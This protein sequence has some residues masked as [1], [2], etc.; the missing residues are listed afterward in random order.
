VAPPLGQEPPPDA[1]ALGYGLLDFDSN[2]NC[3]IDGRR[4]E[5]VIWRDPP[6]A[7]RY[8]VRVDTFSMCGQ[9]AARWTVEA[10]RDGAVVSRATGV[11]TDADTRFSHQA[12]AGVLALEIDVP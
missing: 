12:G 4:Q 1:V 2:A 6:A 7:G 3:V 11:G 8:L 10:T 5:N 9:P